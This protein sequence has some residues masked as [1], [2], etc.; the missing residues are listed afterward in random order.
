METTLQV[1]RQKRFDLAALVASVAL[2]LA[3]RAHAVAIHVGSVSGAPG[4]TQSLS[5]TLSTEGS[6]V[7]ETQNDIAFQAASPIAAMNGQPDCRVNPAINKGATTFA[8]QPSGCSGAACTGVR[9]L[10][11]SFSNTTPIPDGSVLYTCN[12][13]ISA[14]ASGTLPLTCSNAGASDPNGN[15]LTTTCSNGEV[16]VTP[17]SEGVRINV[18]GATAT[19]GETITV[20]VSL[21]T[22]G[23]DVAGTQ[24]RLDF[25]SPLRIVALANGDPDCVVEP[26][27]KKEA[28]SFRFVPIGCAGL[29]CTGVRA[30]VLSFENSNPIPDD[31]LLYTCRVAVAPNATVGDYVVG[32]S[33]LGASDPVGTFLP[34]SGTTG[35]ISVRQALLSV[36]IGDAEALPGEDVMVDVRVDTRGSTVVGAQ[37]RI[38][39]IPPLS[40]AALAT[41]EPDC[42]VNPAIHKGASV[43][44]FLPIG[45]VGASCTAM[46]AV[47]LAFDDVVRIANG[48]TLYTC[49]V[50][51]D[52]NA[53]PG[54]YALRNSEMSGADAQGN[55]LPASGSDGAVTVG[56]EGA[57]VAI[58]I[59][60]VRAISGQRTSVDVRLDALDGDAPSVA[61]TQNE[62]FFDPAAPIA[63]TD[64]GKP[65]CTV[66]PDIHKDGTDFL[67]LPPDC[68]PDVTCTGIRAFVLA[69]ENTGA[70][71]DGAVLY[72]C[73][74]QVAADTAVGVYPLHNANAVG[75]DPAGQP[76]V[77]RGRDGQ[78]EV[79][80]A[81]DCDGNGQ[82][83][84][85]ELLRGVNIL[86][87]SE[88]LAAC[89]V[90]DVDGSGDVRVSEIVQAVSSALRGCTFAR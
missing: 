24:N 61:G 35:T 55:F 82:V 13:V 30:F 88:P 51:V 1:M 63:A 90:F 2:M 72:S 28:T 56:L 7:A 26:S 81:G 45:C 68:T 71:P 69:L 42:T 62:I 73:A 25:A 60:S 39:F 34:A 21:Q 8:F 32:N 22:M 37:N 4:S 17:T 86:L 76:V 77:L 12:I 59:G 5:V 74:V 27:I 50:H 31:S 64:Q 49:R 18:G 36:D 47:L 84:I 52:A 70:I 15:A 58:D 85:F 10:V 89:P 54:T 78:I 23:A 67:F 80:C 16:A 38:D 75:S 48:A 46:R 29:G 6:I 65:D 44:G 41:G 33:E 11:L 79:I 43:F 40:I 83:A 19:A 3:A 66:N 9:A 57:L 14:S 53:D 20:G 87:G